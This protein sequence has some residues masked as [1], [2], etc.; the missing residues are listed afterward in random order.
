M[1]ETWKWVTHN[2]D[3]FQIPMLF[4][5]KNPVSGLHKLP[6]LSYFQIESS[7]IEVNC[8]IG[9]SKSTI[10]TLEQGV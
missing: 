5:K 3:S 9:I 10:K 1:S 8:R 6:K 2:L 4:G 7:K